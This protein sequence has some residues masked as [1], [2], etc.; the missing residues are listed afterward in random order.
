MVGGRLL[1]WGPF[2]VAL[3]LLMGACSVPTGS[4]TQKTRVDVRNYTVSVPAAE[5]GNANTL[6]APFSFRAL[7]VK[8]TS[9]T[10]T[11]A[12]VV[13][14][15]FS[16]DGILWTE[17]AAV[18]LEPEGADNA[19]PS[20]GSLQML[21]E[22]Y[23][24]AGYQTA[25][26]VSD[27]MLTLS[28]IEPGETPKG[29]LACINK[30]T[31][32]ATKA[33]AAKPTIVSR[34]AWGCPDGESSPLWSPEYTTV[35]VL[36]VHHTAGSN[37]ASDWP[38]VVRSV[39]D[40]HTNTQ[41]WGD[42]GY[43]YLIDPNGVIYEGRAGGD[44]VKAAH[45]SCQN[46]GTM[47]I[48]LMGTFTSATP[49]SAALASLEHLLAWK[50]NKDGLNPL[51]TAYHNGTHLTLNTICGHRDANA[52]YP[53]YACSTTTCPGD[54]L[55][56]LLP[57]VRTNVMQTIATI[58]GG[59]VIN[60]NRSATNRRDV[61]LAL[62]WSGGAGTGVVRMRFSDDGAHWTAW[63]PLRST[64]AYTLPEGPDGHRTVRV[65]YLDQM[66][67]RSGTYSDY[68]LLDTTPATGAIL[69]N[70]GAATATTQA[71]TLKLTWADAGAGV[72][73]MRFS[74]D[75]A[76]W[77][78]WETLKATRAHT[79][80]AGLGYHTV[81]AQYLDGAGNYSAVYNDY[82]KLVAP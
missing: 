67:N 15:R 52:S 58:T 10:G 80:P 54:A 40:Y 51:G 29:A 21:E 62:S 60:G 19:V 35:N 59:I 14:V 74:D 79:L 78:A 77:T 56:A 8:W 39:W 13:R 65:Q 24:Y 16:K 9:A 73:R 4:G 70:D 2:A 43:N 7:A 68:I 50:T 61:T 81:R 82:I 28:C 18:T 1:F 37:T 64:L 23:G 5:A 48:G 30:G 32:P 57:T 3:P 12:P 34:D 41:G 11:P 25:D 27:G 46:S 45:F 71:V 26:R 63:Q 53:A 22:G 66:N 76:H 33:A 20:Y 49:T 69:I 72:S 36:V 38:A 44:N 55:Y 42:I 47:G 17:W 31:E 75:G 6:S